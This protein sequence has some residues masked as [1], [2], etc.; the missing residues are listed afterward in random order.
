MPYAELSTG[1]RMYYEEAGA[2]EPLVLLYGTGGDHTLW[3]PLR[4]ALADHF[5]LVLPDPRGTGRTDKPVEEPWPM[6]LLAADVAALL[7]ALGIPAAH[8]GGLSQGS[9]V[10]QEVAIRHP[11]RVLSL[12]LFNT[13]GRTDAFLRTLFG[14]ALRL[15]QALDPEDLWA[16]NKLMLFSPDAHERRPDLI[17]RFREGYAAATAAAPPEALVRLVEA[18]LGHD[19]LDRLGLVRAPTLVLAGEQDMTF[20]PRYPRQVAERIPGARFVLLEGE[21]SSH[22]MHLERGEEFLEAALGFLLDARRRDAASGR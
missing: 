20:M 18:N 12:S 6:A 1:I 4:P 9:A 19:A 22:L 14:H 3:E 11:Q 16:F 17:E 15:V 2:G 7:D 13:W 10:A 21:G 8:L 5:R